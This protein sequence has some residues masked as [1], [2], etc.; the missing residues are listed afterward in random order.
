MF[1]LKPSEKEPVVMPDNV[2]LNTNREESTK[3]GERQLLHTSGL[4]E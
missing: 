4:T 2:N 3:K 1:T